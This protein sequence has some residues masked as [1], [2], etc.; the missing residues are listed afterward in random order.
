MQSFYNINNIE[1]NV[2]P[3]SFYLSFKKI[4]IKSNNPKWN[5]SFKINNIV[6]LTNKDNKDINKNQKS[7]RNDSKI[8]KYEITNNSENIK[9]FIKFIYFK[10]EFLSENSIFK[11][12]L[13]KAY[14]IK[15]DI[16]MKINKRFKL[17]EI[18]K[19]IKNNK[20]LKD[21]KYSDYD[22]HFEYIYNFLNEKQNDYINH[23]K[24]FFEEKEIINCNNEECNLNLKYSTTVEIAEVVFAD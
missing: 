23:I 8:F 19:M 13:N 14:I 18:S 20:E 12:V 4:E 7:S 17:N 24:Q 2:K 5:L 16:F 11:N 9:K 15:K 22:K 10:K 6:I 21:I 3:I 1:N